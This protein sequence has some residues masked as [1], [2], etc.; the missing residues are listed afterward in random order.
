MINFYNLRP[1]DAVLCLNKSISEMIRFV[2]TCH[3]RRF[4]ALS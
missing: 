1:K 4:K 2:L 3:L